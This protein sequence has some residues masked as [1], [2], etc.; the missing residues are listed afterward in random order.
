MDTTRCWNLFRVV[1]DICVHNWGKDFIDKEKIRF[2]IYG[3]MEDYFDHF[4]LNSFIMED[5]KES[6]RHRYFKQ[7]L[8][9]VVYKHISR[10]NV[11]SLGG[12]L[13]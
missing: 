3:K 11:A 13:F 9:D 6:S 2:Q 8:L 10:V 5:P 4:I 12:S 7:N 1:P